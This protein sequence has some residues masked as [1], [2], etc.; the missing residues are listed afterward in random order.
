MTNLANSIE[1]WNE[2][3]LRS[4]GINAGGKA[5]KIVRNAGDL[6]SATLWDGTVVTR[7]EYLFDGQELVKCAPY[8][9]HF[10]YATPAGWKGW[11]LYCT[12]GSIAGTVG[13][14]AYSK[15]ASPTSTGKMIVC[16]HHTATKNNVGIGTHADGSTE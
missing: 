9:L 6:Q 16:L 15:L 7:Q 5:P 12:C 10:I 3:V 2:R 11:G 1:Q 4:R 13:L 8:E 14:N